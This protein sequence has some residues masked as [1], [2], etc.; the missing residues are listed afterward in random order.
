[1]TALGTV[2]IQSTLSPKVVTL[3]LQPVPGALIDTGIVIVKT[4]AAT[5]S[6]PASGLMWPRPWKS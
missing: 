5:T 2:S 6:P 3:D 1:M 4:G